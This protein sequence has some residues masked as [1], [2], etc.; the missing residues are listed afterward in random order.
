MSLFEKKEEPT[1]PGMTIDGSFTCMTCGEVVDEGMY[2]PVDSI[3]IWK[4]SQEHKSATENFS[5]GI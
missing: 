2:F 5:L 3:L 1:T 4:C